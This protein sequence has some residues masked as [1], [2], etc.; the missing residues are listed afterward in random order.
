MVPR[1]GS[2]YAFFTD[3]FGQMHK[4]WGPLPAFMYAFLMVLIVRPCSVT[5]VILTSAEYLV[6]FIANFICFDEEFDIMWLKRV[7]AIIEI[8]KHY[9]T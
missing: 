5:I 4:F 2:E 6:E 3:S 8:C 9:S 7:I 1:S